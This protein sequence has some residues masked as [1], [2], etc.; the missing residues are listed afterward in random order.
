MGMKII[1]SS[2]VV[3]KEKNYVYDKLRAMEAEHLIKIDKIYDCNRSGT[4]WNVRSKQEMIDCF[5]AECD[6]FICLVPDYVVGQATWGE[7]QYV[8]DRKKQGA[9]VAISVF[10]PLDFPESAKIKEENVPKGK[11]LFSKMEEEANKLLGSQKEQYSVPYKYNDIDDLL[12]QLEKA[13]QEGYEEDKA[14]WSQHIGY[15]V[16]SGGEIEAGRLFFDSNRASQEWGF[17]EGSENYIWR[18]SVDGKLN[19]KLEETEIKFLFVTGKPTSGKSRAIYECLHSTLKDKNVV[20]MKSDNIMTI[21]QNLRIEIEQYRKYNGLPQRFEDNDYIFVCDQINDVFRQAR[22]PDELRLSFLKIISEN[23]NCRLLASG[24]RNS[25]DSFVDDSDDIIS[26]LEKVYGEGNSSVITIPSISKDVDSLDILAFLHQNYAGTSGETIGDFIHELNV[27]KQEIVRD[28]YDE[29]N[30]NSYLSRLLKAIQLTLVYRN[31]TALLLPISILRKYY[32]TVDLLK[33]KECTISC[34]DFLIRKNVVKITDTEYE[35]K[36]IFKFPEN[37]FLE[38]E[39]EKYCMST[40]VED[41]EY[42]KLIPDSYTFTVNELVWEYLL[43]LSQKDDEKAILYDLYKTK[44]LGAAMLILYASYPHAPT[45]RRLVSRVPIRIEWQDKQGNDTR[46]KVAWK[47]SMSMLNEL[48][49]KIES[50]SELT[51]LLNILIGRAQSVEEVDSVLE[52]MSNHTIEIDDSTIGE[53]YK[54][55]LQRLNK[56]TDGFKDFIKRVRELNEAQQKRDSLRGRAWTYTDFYRVRWQMV[57]FSNNYDEAYNLVFN[58]LYNQTHIDQEGN[59]LKGKN[60][61][62]YISRQINSFE[63]SNLDMLI[64]QLAR[65]CKNENE[66]KR[67][68]K[69]HQYYQIQFTPYVL[70]CIGKVLKNGQSIERVIDTILPTLK[71]KSANGQLYESMVAYF[72]PYLSTFTESIKLYNKWHGDLRVAEN[73]NVR[74]VSLCLRNCQREEFQSALGFVNRMP[75]SC[76]NGIVLNLLVSAAPNPE[77]AL[78]LVNSMK[79]SDIDEYTLCNCLRCIDKVKQMNINRDDAKIPPEQIFIM[80]YEIINH[81]KLKTLRTRPRCLQKIFRLVNFR[82][83][84]HYVMA[85]AQGIQRELAYNAYI[86]ATRISYRSFSEAYE[87][88]YKKTIGKYFDTRGTITPDIFNAMCS[89]YYK[90]KNLESQDK[91]T[92]YAE[93]LRTD[94]QCLESGSRGGKLI[95]DEFFFLNYHVKFEGSPLFTENA[96]SMSSVF[97][98]WFEGKEGNYNPF[99]LDVL[100]RYFDYILSQREVT[101]EKKWLQAMT[102][103]KTYV[104]FFETYKRSF[105]PDILVFVNLFKIVEKCNNRNDCLIF[106]DEELEKLDIKRDVR[107]SYYLQKFE[108]EHHFK[109]NTSHP[110]PI[111]RQKENLDK[112]KKSV[113]TEEVM[114][115]L[116]QEITIEGFVTPSIINR[117][118]SQYRDF[119]KI[120]SNTVSTLLDKAKKL[121]PKDA[122]HFNLNYLTKFCFDNLNKQFCERKRMVL[123]IQRHHTKAKT[124]GQL[125][126]ELEALCKELDKKQFEEIVRFIECHHLEDKLTLRGIVTLALLAKD[127]NERIKWLKKLEQSEEI[128][129]GLFGTIATEPVIVHTDISISRKYFL[130]W[131]AIYQDIYGDTSVI[132]KFM[133]RMRW[134][135]LGL[136]LKYEIAELTNLRETSEMTSPNQLKDFYAFLIKEG[137]TAALDTIILIMRFYEFCPQYNMSYNYSEHLSF[138]DAIDLLIA[139]TG[140]SDY[141]KKMSKPITK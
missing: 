68:I 43:E 137:K 53:M 9:P 124:W 135:T 76:V 50:V 128:N 87:D 21:C 114:A 70:H 10:H 31:V 88:I 136:H 25:L 60:A 133:N 73:H 107:L 61:V 46:L 139:Y 98:K 120:H 95:R 32:P 28:I 19:Q 110:Q 6:W 35:E 127:V 23:G 39:S 40:L 42:T 116:E 103:Y 11:I 115:V 37:D 22:V 30:K 71:E 129:E 54:F 4:F 2:A 140:E 83:Q 59:L 100:P 29:S 74:L 58:T 89:K 69:C 5:I 102:V 131:L 41:E 99:N 47:F 105:T 112:I 82:E 49:F 8:I 106:I 113:R 126:R 117:A 132:V 66:I 109:Y 56:R 97:M 16:K 125:K 36:E 80:A 7:L 17:R 77:E 48:D 93:K 81:P 92:E 13:Y 63:K 45:L 57:L 96:M 86:G 101:V 90:D 78:S 26:P 85:V 108:H 94:I 12:L 38:L 20:V 84:E 33:F 44:E 123:I 138:D 72:V 51:K 122:K 64:G 130:K 3:L 52:I 75:K 62:C 79:P 15:F 65:S 67:L 1:I 18:Q 24:T 104:Q 14:F 55:A 34:L 91:K 111:N 134:N 27:K 118:L 119:Q 141:W 121:L